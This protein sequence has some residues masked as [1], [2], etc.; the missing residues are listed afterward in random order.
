MTEV[1]KKPGTERFDV[2]FFSGT[3]HGKSNGRHLEKMTLQK[4]MK[5]VFTGY[6]ADNMKNF[7]DAGYHFDV[8]RPDIEDIFRW[9][10]QGI[11]IVPFSVTVKKE[12]VISY[13]KAGFEVV[14]MKAS[15]F[16][17]MKKAYKNYV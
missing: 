8:R 10:E 16:R 2:Y 6:F 13:L 17:K 12:E 11:V 1:I 5:A 3:W 4:C 14:F 7:F 9:V 15:E